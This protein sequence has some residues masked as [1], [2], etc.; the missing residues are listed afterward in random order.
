MDIRTPAVCLQICTSCQLLNADIGLASPSSR[1][2]VHNS[3]SVNRW[4]FDPDIVKTWRYQNLSTNTTRQ[5][6]SKA[7]TSVEFLRRRKIE[8]R[9]I[10]DLVLSTMVCFQFNLE[11][12]EL[13]GTKPPRDVDYYLQSWQLSELVGVCIQEIGRIKH[14]MQVKRIGGLGTRIHITLDSL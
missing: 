6:W 8:M 9:T 12:R 2:K 13:Y 11:H 7:H 14:G 3:G 10:Q 4:F 5:L 1:R